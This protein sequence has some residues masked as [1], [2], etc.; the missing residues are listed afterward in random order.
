[1][2]R[3][4]IRAT[5]LLGII[6]IVGIIAVQIYWVKRAF[7]LREQQFRQTT[8]VALRNVANSISRLYNLADIENPVSQQSS[9]YY[10]V[11]LRVPLDAKI[12]EH[13]LKEEFKKKNL[14]TDFEYGIYDCDTDKIVYGALITGNFEVEASS[15]Q[16]LPKTDKYLNYFG[17]RFPQKSSY[18]AGKLDIWI[19]SSLITL[20]VTF[21]F[22]YAMFIILKQ[23][24]LSEVQRDFINNMTHE[25][26]TP[27]STIQVATDV[28]AN[29]KILEQPERLQ[30]YVQIIRQE[31][32]RLKN[33]V[34]AVLTTAQLTRGKIE[35]NIELQDLNAL[36]FE[37][38]EGVKAQLG[39]H[40]TLSLDAERS[41]VLADRVHLINVIRNLLENAVKYSSKPP[42]I[43]IKT[44]NET[45]GVVVEVSDKGIGIPKEY[46]HKIFDKFYRVPTGNVH[47][48][49]GFG[50]GLSYVKQIVQA[51]KWHIE[52]KSEYQKG[53]SFYVHIPQQN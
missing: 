33:Q 7:D 43:S 24:R 51:H 42:T 3:N 5:L 31:N 15:P 17:V 13:F 36:I 47:N 30:K 2:S 12:L 25:F 48:V 20:I 28:L 6:S 37:V 26:Q 21:F 52:L 50:L 14:D 45:D 32:N 41:S 38:T 40:L 46:Q 29:K 34:E 4:T 22:G 16:I 19:I 10:V 11:N 53:T 39:T 35:M 8:M 23:K 18:L 1:M 9:D 44:Y 27:I 49:K